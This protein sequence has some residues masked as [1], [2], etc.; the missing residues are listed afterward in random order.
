MWVSG[1][2]EERNCLGCICVSACVQVCLRQGFTE[3]ISQKPNL[4]GWMRI[5]WRRDGGLQVKENTVGESR[6]VR[7]QGVFGNKKLSVTV[8]TACWLVESRC[9]LFLNESVTR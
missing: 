2:R 6:A 3:N 5:R 9:F 4:D 7:G 1:R 8:Y